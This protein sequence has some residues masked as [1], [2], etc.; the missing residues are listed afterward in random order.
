MRHP[1]RIERVAL[2]FTRWV[3]SPQS[4]LLHSIIFAFVIFLLLIKA[5]SFDVLILIFNT[6]VSLEAIYLALCIQMTV[7]Y[8]T[9]AVEEV[10]ED[11]ELMQEDIGEIQEDVGEL[12]EDVED[13]GEDVEEISE[14]EKAEE[15]AEL[16]R[17]LE[18]KNTLSTIQ[19]DLR[20]LMQ[21]I[22]RLQ[23]NQHPPTPTTQ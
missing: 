9:R 15:V 6:A 4:I 21:D 1:S 2:A 23:K 17:K 7:N 16:L 8:Q 19:T 12:Q 20:K 13:I 22:E 18:Q 14:D 3:G 11:I 5:F 10:S